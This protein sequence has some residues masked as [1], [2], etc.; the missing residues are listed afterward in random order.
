[1]QT[2]LLYLAAAA[3]LGLASGGAALAIQPAGA[4]QPS[5]SGNGVASS[6]ASRVER[7]GTVGAVD[8]RKRTLVVD[9]VAYPISASPV[10]VHG[11]DGQRDSK[12]VELKPGMQIRFSTSRSNFSATDQVVEIWVTDM[13]TRPVG[14]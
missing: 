10:I 13:R 1:M 4:V 8:W 9:N 2:R 12:T 3:L 14:K 7:G 5:G 11:P 6:S